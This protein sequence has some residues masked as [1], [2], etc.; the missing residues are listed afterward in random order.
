MNRRTYPVTIWDE[1]FR[2][3]LIP[4]YVAVAMFAVGILFG[5]LAIET[6][7]PADILSLSTYVR[8]FVG[9]E[10]STPTYAGLFQP[11]LVS[12]LKVLGLFYILGVSVAGMPLV[13]V[14][15][16]FRGFVLG[17]TVAFLISSL[18]WE[19]FALAVIAVVLQNLFIVPALLIVSGVALGF[20]WQL[21]ATKGGSAR[22]SLIQKFG[23]FTTLV[24][25]M[26]LVIVVGTAVEA[27]GS[28]FLIHIAGQWGI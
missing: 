16:F 20:S 15:L 13:L 21:I 27:Y 25:L 5:V 1:Y 2:Q 23:G 7:T 22:S 10:T 9:M 6:L 17:F 3:Y 14:T 4:I 11:A 24:V 12:N 19:G 18:H 26:A 28:P 8:Q